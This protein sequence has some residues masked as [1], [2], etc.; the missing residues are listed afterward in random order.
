MSNVP[1]VAPSARNQSA[2]GAVT[3]ALAWPA[4]NITPPLSWYIA[5]STMIGQ[6]GVSEVMTPDTSPEASRGSS[7]FT[8]IVFRVFPG[9]PG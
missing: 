4:L 5:R 3:P 9:M 7:P 2:V 8:W 1:T 6:S